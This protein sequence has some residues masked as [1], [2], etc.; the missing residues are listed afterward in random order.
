MSNNM[1][2]DA[3]LRQARAAERAGNIDKAVAL[4]SRVVDRYPHTDAA[5]EAQTSLAGDARA[6][7]EARR[8]AYVSGAPPEQAT[9]TLPVE[10]TVQLV[11]VVDVDISFGQLVSLFVK[12]S[13]AMIP[14]AIILGAIGFAVTVVLLGL[15]GSVGR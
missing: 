5:R 13:I 14:A 1:D 7:A 10:P 12:A 9:L 11:R 3:L 2:A 8:A 15:F 6:T 4:Y